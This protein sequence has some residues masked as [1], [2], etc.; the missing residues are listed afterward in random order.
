MNEFSIY[1]IFRLIV[2]NFFI[3]LLSAIVFGV[4]TFCYCRFN[5]PE[6]FSASGSILVTNGG[7]ID[8]ALN[9]QYNNG[10]VNNGDITASINLLTTVK[11]LLTSQDDI[12]EELSEKLDGKYSAA[13]LKSSVTISKR[14]DYSMLIDIRFE[15][16]DRL[17]A[18]K[19]TNM[20]L[21]LTSDAISKVIPGALT[22]VIT[23]STGAAKTYPR[24][25][26]ST[27]VAMVVGAILAFII[28][29]IISLFNTT[30]KSEEEFKERYN[31]PVLGD[32]PDFAT[33]KSG[34]YMKSYYKG[35]SY[36]G[37]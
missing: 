15:L 4:A 33:A 14:E 19:V 35:G 9:N 34:K 17:D 6:R 24:T 28:V 36:Y 26:S 21:E 32:I 5:L 31:I 1:H 2:K 7:V 23:R 37:N 16:N 3:I 30:I 20:F 13:Q 11:D 12:Y 22:N 27:L 10:T 29:Y 18:P 8:E 25:F